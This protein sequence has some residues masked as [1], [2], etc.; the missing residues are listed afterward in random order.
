MSNKIIYKPLLSKREAAKVLRCSPE[1]LNNLIRIGELR[2]FIDRLNHVSAKIP[3]S[4][5]ESY[6]DSH[7]Y[8]I[9]D[10]NCNLGKMTR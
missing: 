10:L 5:I 2:L 8:N 1:K 3:I 7:T 9:S 4:S 6:I